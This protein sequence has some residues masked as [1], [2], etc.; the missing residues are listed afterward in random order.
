MTVGQ[1]IQALKKYPRDMRVGLVV[2]EY[3]D[4][5]RLEPLTDEKRLF[6]YAQV[7]PVVEQKEI[8]Q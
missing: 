7:R 8:E 4:A 6:V 5:F 3:T 2:T 1:L